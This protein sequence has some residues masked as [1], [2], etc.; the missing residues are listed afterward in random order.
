[1]AG[2]YWLSCDRNRQRSKRLERVAKDSSTPDR[3]TLLD[4]DYQDT[5]AM[6]Q[7]MSQLRSERGPIDVVVAWI[8]NTAP[9]ALPVIQHVFAQ[10]AT[11]WRLFHVC[12]SRAWIKPPNV[13]EVV[14]CLYR[15]IILGFVLEE[16]LARWLTNDEIARGVIRAIET[17]QAQSII[18]NVEPWERRPGY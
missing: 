10:Q 17:D 11:E 3:F 7:A 18:G 12:G 2:S 8:H 9:K 16:P 1:M 15:W 6:Q 4:L 14:S 5:T 13:E